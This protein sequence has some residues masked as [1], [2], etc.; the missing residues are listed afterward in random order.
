[1]QQEKRFYGYTG[2]RIRGLGAWACLLT[3]VLGDPGQVV[4]A[5]FDDWNHDELR[6]FVWME[7]LHS[8]FEISHATGRGLHNDLTLLTRLDRSFPRI[9]RLH[10]WQHVY[11]RCQ[12]LCDQ[13]LRE[14]IHI[15]IN[16]ECS[17]HD[18]EICVRPQAPSPKS[19][20]PRG[21]TMPARDRPRDPRHPRY[22]PKCE[23]TRR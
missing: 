12:L 14:L 23:S 21:L 22:R 9:D 3:G 10:L 11:A 19:Q 4:V 16:R 18:D 20:A 15:S 7:R 6:D 8:E 1:M 17:Q 5:S 13:R 2:Q